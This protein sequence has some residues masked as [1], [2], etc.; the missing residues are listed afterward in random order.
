MRKYA[1]LDPSICSI[2]KWRRSSW[3]PVLLCPF[4]QPNLFRVLQNLFETP[5]CEQQ[6]F[7]NVTD[8]PLS[9]PM[10]YS[11]MHTSLNLQSSEGQH[12]YQRISIIRSRSKSGAMRISCKKVQT[13]VNLKAAIQIPN[14]NWKEPH[15]SSSKCSTPCLAEIHNP[16]DKFWAKTML[17]QH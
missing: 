9:H 7:R 13:Q 16:L 15:A 4:W 5:Q 1:P 17:L 11:H 12:T 6:Y 14:K 2:S 10:R 8:Q 3:S